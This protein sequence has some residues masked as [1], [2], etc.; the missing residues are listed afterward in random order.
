MES[1]EG[2]E[3][4]ENNDAQELVNQ[5]NDVKSENRALHMGEVTAIKRLIRSLEWRHKRQGQ[6]LVRHISGFRRENL[7]YRDVMAD[8]AAYQARFHELD[9]NYLRL[10]QVLEGDEDAGDGYLKDW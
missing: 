3:M 8:I 4:S 9:G 7:R 10:Y 6:N 1:D 2:L 5:T